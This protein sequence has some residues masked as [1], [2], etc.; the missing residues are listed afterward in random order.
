MCSRANTTG[1]TLRL[2]S[3]HWALSWDHTTLPNNTPLIAVA[4]S[5][6][7]DLVVC[8]SCLFAPG[9]LYE[10][11]VCDFCFFVLLYLLP[12]LVWVRVRVSRSRD[13]Q[14]QLVDYN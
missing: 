2:A 7:M 11:A 1:L 13:E 12:F 6:L 8:D 3:R 10:D 14:K 9:D 5:A 4:A